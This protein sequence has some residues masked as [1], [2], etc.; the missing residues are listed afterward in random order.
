MV[1]GAG[2]TADLMSAVST[3]VFV[4]TKDAGIPGIK[5]GGG[6]NGLPSLLNDPAAHFTKAQPRATMIRL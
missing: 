3:T 6:P 5:L 2:V 1:A 4:N